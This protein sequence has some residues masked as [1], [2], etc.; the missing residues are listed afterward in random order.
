M[1]RL[2]LSNELELIRLCHRFFDPQVSPG[3]LEDDGE[4]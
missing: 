2:Q 3:S 1:H 4:E